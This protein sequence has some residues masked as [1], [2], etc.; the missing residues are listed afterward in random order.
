M[1]LLTH[2]YVNGFAVLASFS[3]VNCFCFIH[4]EI[5]QQDKKEKLQR[6]INIFGA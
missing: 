2:L 1:G 6:N 3:Y 4:V 5:T